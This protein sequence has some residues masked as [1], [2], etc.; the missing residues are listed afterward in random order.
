MLFWH[1]SVMT[2]TILPTPSFSVQKCYSHYFSMNETHNNQASIIIQDMWLEMLYWGRYW[3]P[4]WICKTFFERF[5][6]YKQKH[7]TDTQL[8][9]LIFVLN[10][11]MHMIGFEIFALMLHTTASWRD[12]C[13]TRQNIHTPH[14]PHKTYTHLTIH[15]KHTHTSP[16]T[17]NIHTPH[18]PHKTYKHLTI[19]LQHLPFLSNGIQ[20]VLLIQLWIGS[21]QEQ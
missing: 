14:H 2:P 20:T 1:F 3:P 9:Y 12:Y 16:S 6:M 21:T 19:H 13:I 4:N 7:C 8:I 10:V 17:Q 11:S 15:T 18:H 5:I